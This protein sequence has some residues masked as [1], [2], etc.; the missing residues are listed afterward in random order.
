MQGFFEGAV[1]REI[2]LDGQGGPHGRDLILGVEL[3]QGIDRHPSDLPIGVSQETRDQG[4]PL[5]G[6][7]LTA[8]ADTGI[9]AA[10][11]TAWSCPTAWPRRNS[12][13][14]LSSFRSAGC[15]P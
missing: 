15:A 13:T 14:V 10:V 11:C 8:N 6:L 12:P 9:S 7:R 5:P 3:G 2:G 4:N 1:D